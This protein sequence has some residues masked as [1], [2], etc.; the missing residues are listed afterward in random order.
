[1]P[2]NLTASGAGTSTPLAAFLRDE[3][4]RGVLANALGSDW[5]AATIHAGGINEAVVHLAADP[6]AG[7]LIVDFADSPDMFKALDRL[8]EVCTPGTLVVALGEVNDVTLYRRLR[9]AGVADY[10]VK[11]VTAESFGHALHIASQPTVTIGHDKATHPK[12]DVIAVVG[13]RGGV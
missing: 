3:N 5:P 6:S 13:A 9:A 12:G 1:M 2:I 7:I 11:P 8:A 4:T 10:L